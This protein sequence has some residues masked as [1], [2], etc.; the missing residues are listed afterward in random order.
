MRKITA[1]SGA[2]AAAAVV[3]ALGAVPAQADTV[4]STISGG[5]LSSTTSAPTLS[6]VTLNGSNT[7]TS[8]G[9]APSAWSVTDA[10]GT[11][12]AWTLSVT[13]TNLTSAAGTVETTA[14]TI[15]ASDLTITPGTVTAGTGADPASNITAGALALSTTSQALVTAAGP[16]KGTYS[17]TPSFSLAIPAN[18]YRSN[19]SG[20]VGTTALNP[21]ASTLTYTV[22]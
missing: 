11:G 20:A 15:P 19:Y 1:I 16:D 2:V 8:T 3:V 13:A 10:R 22:G 21:Y 17:L 12:A 14:R 18:A 9:V 5:N 4:N 7:Q 6:A